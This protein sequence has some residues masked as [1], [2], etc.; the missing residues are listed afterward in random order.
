MNKKSQKDFLKLL[1]HSVILKV[2]K[3]QSL[4]LMITQG[5]LMIIQGLQMFT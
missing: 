2:M 1:F 3:Q 4:H 5:P